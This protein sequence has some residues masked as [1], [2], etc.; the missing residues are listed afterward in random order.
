[1]TGTST[2]VYLAVPYDEKDEAKLHGARWD[3]DVKKWWIDRHK[4]AEYPGI[5]RWIT[6]SPALAAKAREAAAFLA[7]QRKQHHP[8]AQTESGR[9]R[10]APGAR[11]GSTP[12]TTP[13]TSLHLPVCDCQMPPWEDCEH[14]AAIRSGSR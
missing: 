2:R 4:I 13:C 1:M 11:R 8:K 7:D 9:P 14:T 10:K 12:I 6:D 5:A 3:P